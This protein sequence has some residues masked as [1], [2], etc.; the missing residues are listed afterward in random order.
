MSEKKVYTPMSLYPEVASKIVDV[1]K[2][3]KL[4]NNSQSVKVL[5]A[6]YDIINGTGYGGTFTEAVKH[7]LEGD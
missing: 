2:A 1:K 6:A 3:L 4:D 7:A 5:L